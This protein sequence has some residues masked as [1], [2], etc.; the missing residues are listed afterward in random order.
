MDTPD[1]I[2]I[3]NELLGY[4]GRSPACRLLEAVVFTAKPDVQALGL[5]QQMAADSEQH[6]AWLTGLILELGGSPGP[7]AGDVTTADLHYHDLRQVL[8]RF[9]REYES[10]IGKYSSASPHLADEPQA[11]ELISRIRTR[12]QQHLAKL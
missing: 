1:V 7:H 3:L 5:V 4:E 9:I 8:P 10:L 12:H 6:V 11:D 2:D